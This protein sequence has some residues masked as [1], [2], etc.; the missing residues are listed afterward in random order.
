M[1]DQDR[2]ERYLHGYEEWTRQWMSQRTAARD[3]AFLVPHLRTGMDVVDC[4][5]GPGSI[6]VGLA[7]A[8]APGQV[9]GIDIDANSR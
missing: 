2:N 4:G 9:I 7:E 5:C 1:T 6:T 3:L 8:V